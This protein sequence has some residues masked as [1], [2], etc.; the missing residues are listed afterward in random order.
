MGEQRVLKQEREDMGRAHVRE[1]LR[2]RT[3]RE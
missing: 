2:D 3:H 1:R